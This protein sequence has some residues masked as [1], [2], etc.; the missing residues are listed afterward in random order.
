MGS[1]TYTTVSTD[2]TTETNNI[3]RRVAVTDGGH[4]F[5]VDG[6]LS[7]GIKIE[8]TTTTNTLD[9]GV[10]AGVTDTLQKLPGLFTNLSTSNAAYL[11]GAQ[12]QIADSYDG[13]SKN[14]A[15]A[16][17]DFAAGLRTNSQDA[18]NFSSRSLDNILNFGRDQLDKSTLDTQNAIAAVRATSERLM[19]FVQEREKD[20]NER[21]FQNAL[22]WLVGGAVIIAI[23]AFGSKGAR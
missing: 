5:T 7:G 4:A 1:R 2:T 23:F 9:G 6:D 15:G 13:Y 12:K 22:P 21:G 16:Y 18:F 3:D 8:N 20:P 14:L 17:G 10:I 11:S 19:G